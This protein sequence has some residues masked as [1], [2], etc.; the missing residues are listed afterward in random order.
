MS[1]KTIAQRLR[2][3]S[4][5]LYNGAESFCGRFGGFDYGNPNGMCNTA[6]YIAE[7]IEQEHNALIEAQ[8]ASAHH[9]MLAYAEDKGMPMEESETIT[10]WLDRWFVPRPRFEDGEPVQF[11]D[12][13]EIHNRSGLLDKGT[14]QSF[15]PNNGPVWMLSLVGYDHERLVRFDPETCAIKRPA[16]KVLD[17]DGIEIKVGDTVWSR[18]FTEA[19]GEMTVTGFT[20]PKDGSNVCVNTDA[21]YRPEEL[22]HKEPD[23][24][25][26]LRD[27][28]DGF[29]RDCE[30]NADKVDEY[31]DRLTAIM[32][33]DA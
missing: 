11:R 10:Q 31:I 5:D 14:I 13:I 23:S 30:I 15:H 18:M 19:R 2:N 29:M 33:R 25:E 22:T 24:L 3:F 7:Q 28:L 21:A 9:T 27:D 16:P 4:K 12:E 8:G 6:L 20:A 32:E 26:K 1:D 17:A